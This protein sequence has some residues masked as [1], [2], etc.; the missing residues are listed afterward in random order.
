MYNPPR[1]LEGGRALSGTVVPIITQTRDPGPACPAPEGA[2]GETLR[3]VARLA[4]VVAAL[5]VFLAS[6]RLLGFGFERLGGSFSQNLIATTSH[7]FV[8]LFVGLLA[9]SIVQSSSITTSTV[10]GLVS[11][12]LLSIRNAVPIIMGANIGTT[13]TC[14]IVS[15]GHIGRPAEFRRAYAAAT[16]HDFF[17]ILTVLCIFPLELATGWVSRAATA[18][19]NALAGGRSLE[20]GGPIKLLIDPAAKRV[21]ALL[22]QAFSGHA[23]AAAVV[24]GFALLFGSLTLLVSHTR[25]L[26]TGRAEAALD[27][28]LGRGG[29]LGILV[30]LAVTG[31]IQSSSVTTSLLVPLAGAGIVSLEQIYP[32]ALGANIG[33]T[34]T[35]LLASLA[36][37]VRGLA[38]ALTH[39]IFNV[40]GVLIFYPARPL[41]RIPMFL[42][43]QLA[44]AAVRS[45]RN[46]VF[47]VVGVFYAVPLALILIDRLR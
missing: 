43:R 20:F 9:T 6:M 10:V 41:R 18:L 32:V 27:R 42:A 16:V 22:E 28:I 2:R 7:P 24:L 21:F 46:V 38:V 19:A 39:T 3:T 25:A 35:A 45:R 11:A 5:Y 44:D 34:V 31:T 47:F 30:G 33:T 26:A 37:D 13:V 1:C 17:N 36:G 8:A 4:A 23:P 29:P 40:V 12:G 14:T 15:L